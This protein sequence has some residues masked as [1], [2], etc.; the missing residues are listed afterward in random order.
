M[1][2]LT[3]GLDRIYSR[4]RT[5][6]PHRVSSMKPGLSRSEINEMVQVL[7]FNIPSEVR[8]LYQWHDGGSDCWNF[9]FENYEFP[10]LKSAIYLYQ[11]ELKQVQQDYPEVA[12]LFQFRL[13]LFQNPDSG[14]LLTV[15]PDGENGSPVYVHDIECSNHEIRYHNLTN[16]I[17]HAAEWYEN[18][19][20]HE[21][22]REF[23][24][25]FNVNSDT[26]IWLETQP[27]YDIETYLEAKYMAREY[28]IRISNTTGNGLKPS[29]YK[30]FLETTSN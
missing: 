25:E 9:L 5:Q 21:D 24:V 18:V 15:L 8:E 12:K 14:V 29:I 22:G 10:S 23:N 6:V 3:N 13:P 4:L 2:E 16:L 1:S 11:E 26:K 20:L 27:I 28:I 30:H 19:T 17:L 7:P